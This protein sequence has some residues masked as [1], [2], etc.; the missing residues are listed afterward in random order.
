MQKERDVKA[1]DKNRTEQGVSRRGWR[2]ARYST[3]NVRITGSTAINCN[4][5]STVTLITLIALV[6]L[7]SHVTLIT[8]QR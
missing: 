8:L 5:Y 3:G 7:L 4:T 6:T 2:T 1:S